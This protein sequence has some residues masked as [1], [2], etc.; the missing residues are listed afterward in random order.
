M[1]WAFQVG[2]ALA[3]TAFSCRP[4]PVAAEAPPTGGRA[5]PVVRGP[6]PMASGL[7]GEQ[8]QRLV[9]RV[10]QAQFAVFFHLPA[11]HLAQG[12]EEAAFL[13]HQ[14]R[15]AH[16]AGAAGLAEV[17]LII[18]HFETGEPAVAAGV[19]VRAAVG[20]EGDGEVAAVDQRALADP[21]HLVRGVQGQ[22]GGG[23][24]G[25]AGEE[26]G[27]G[28]GGGERV[29]G[30]LVKCGVAGIVG[31]FARYRATVRAVAG[32]S[33]RGGLASHRFL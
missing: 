4:H 26:Q 15:G 31:W 3:A 18:L 1:V 6:K 7:F 5:G 12:L 19:A 28:E 14:G 29:H 8:S 13:L 23:G 25:A 32:R 22:A 27:G 21:F 10:P 17:Q 9:F 20:A 16:H 33:S 24:G 2:K 30:G 11:L